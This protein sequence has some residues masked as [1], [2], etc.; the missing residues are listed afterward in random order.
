MRNPER[1]ADM[2]AGRA[3]RVVKDF[4]RDREVDEIVSV[5]RRLWDGEAA[6]LK[7][8]PGAS[9]PPTGA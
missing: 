2:G 7:R 5:Y 3:C 8:K 1:I 6:R 9:P 4:S